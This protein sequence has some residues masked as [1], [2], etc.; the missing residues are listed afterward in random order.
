VQADLWIRAR[1][2]PKLGIG[3]QVRAIILADAISK[4][5]RTVGLILDDDAP[6]PPPGVRVYRLPPGSV[7]PEEAAAYPTDGAPVVLD[8]SHPSM[9]NDLPEL[10]RRLRRQGRRIGL[11]DGL[12]REAYAPGDRSAAVE[13]VLTPYVIEPAAPARN[14]DKWLHGPDYAVLEPVYA[15]APAQPAQARERLLLVCVS[16]TDP[17][18]LTEA[19][20]KALRAGGLPEGWRADI[21]AG[22]GF[23][24]SRRKALQALT[25]ATSDLSLLIAP[26]NLH[27]ALSKA[28]LALLGPGL[29]KYE[30]AACGTPGLIVLPDRIFAE[31]NRPYAATG[32]ARLLPPGP[33][34]P[35]V[36][37]AAIEAQDAVP[38]ADPRTLIDGAGAQRAAARFI[39]ELFT[40]S[41]DI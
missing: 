13:M 2:G 5:G 8:L 4:A 34:E 3:H 10:V 1:S 25:D 39:S 41:R 11:I 28:R 15:K 19:V 26:A 21:V 22:P 27:S 9:L 30:A 40:E 36:L 35:D 24:Q 14:A 31:M 33:P 18:D 23:T 29:M 12:G 20:T 7:P 6:A 17:W 32:L 16:G 37:H 38:H